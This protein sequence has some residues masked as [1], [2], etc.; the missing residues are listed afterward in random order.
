MTK[1]NV[2]LASLNSQPQPQPADAEVKENCKEVTKKWK[3]KERG[4]SL[5]PRNKWIRNSELNGC[6][7]EIVNSKY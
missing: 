3:A 5:M 7:N 6:L 2:P 1:K 4:Q